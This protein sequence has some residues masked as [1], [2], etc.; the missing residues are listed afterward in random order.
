MRVGCIDIGGTAIKSGVLENGALTDLASAPT[1]AAEGGRAVLEQA[2]QIAAGMRGIGALGVCTCGE[3]DTDAGAIRLADNI[4]GYTGLPVREILW[5]L[6]GLP[7]TVENDANAAAVGE[8]RFGAG[9][10]L[11]HF[12]F[13]SYGTGVGG[14]LILSGGLYRGSRFSA[15]E[16]G[17]LVTHPEALRPGQVGT[18]T[19]ERYASATALVAR[20]K[21]ADPALTDGR[22][23]FARLAEPQVKAVVRAW[24][25][26]VAAGLISLNH[27]LNPEA[28][29]LGG[30][31]MEQPW[32]LEQL[33]AL[34]AP[35]TKPSFRELRL[36]AAELGN[37]AGLLGAGWLALEGG[38]AC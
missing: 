28:L 9:R 27:L 16:V 33:E 21:A 8:A 26:E 32:V 38:P 4:P 1:R 5:Q 11:E 19:Y 24:L 18:G 13:V 37:R 25:A 35:N 23:I 36:L 31:V 15:G 2:A 14:A 34:C 20:A 22:A 10:G 6:T 30:G 17:G 7:V 29:V 12:V 3:V